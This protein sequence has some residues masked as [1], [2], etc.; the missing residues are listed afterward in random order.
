MS[1]ELFDP[2]LNPQTAE[3]RKPA[4]EKHDPP[5]IQWIV[6]IPLEYRAAAFVRTETGVTTNPRIAEQCK[7][8][9]WKCECKDVGENFPLAAV[10]YSTQAGRKMDEHGLWYNNER[11]TANRKSY[12]KILGDFCD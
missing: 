4:P 1:V 11:A 9:D 7:R 8:R 12:P 2:V 6:D 3:F 5:K 10:T